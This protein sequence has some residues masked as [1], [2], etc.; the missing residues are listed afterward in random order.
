MG[1]F[2]NKMKEEYV[3]ETTS[4]SLYRVWMVGNKMFFE[5]KKKVWEVDGLSPQ[6]GGSVP[7]TIANLQPERIIQFN[8]KV[9]RSSPILKVY[10]KIRE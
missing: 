5:R 1:W 4:G 6:E 2:S 7:P 8:E 9:G 10:K 3:V